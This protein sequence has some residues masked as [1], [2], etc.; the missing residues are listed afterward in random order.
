MKIKILPLLPIAI[1]C[2]FGY[3]PKSVADYNLFFK[4]TSTCSS[5][6]TVDAHC[7]SK[8]F[9]TKFNKNNA[10]CGIIKEGVISKAKPQVD[11]Y[12]KKLDDF[13]N[14]N[15]KFY[16]N[17]KNNESAYTHKCSAIFNVEP[18]SK[19]GGFAPVLA[20]GYSRTNCDGGSDKDDLR[21]N[22]RPKL[23]VSD[24]ALK[25]G[26]GF[27]ISCPWEKKL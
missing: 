12:T 4:V 8:Q 17:V 21:N 3:L 13:T 15:I 22:E 6:I 5:D 10:Y 11:I 1:T 14:G 18:D 19:H 26:V 23:I 20:D 24:S 9:T 27:T 16:F 25:H 2:L 7:Y